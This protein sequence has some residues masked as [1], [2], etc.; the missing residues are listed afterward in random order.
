MIDRVTLI[1]LL[2]SQSRGSLGGQ[3]FPATLRKSENGLLL[4][5]A[6]R[7]DMKA[8]YT[9]AFTAVQAYGDFMRN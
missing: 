2:I 6:R 8:S 7:N 9:F 1:E 5:M 3:L 4:A